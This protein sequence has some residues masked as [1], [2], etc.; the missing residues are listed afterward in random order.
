M[1]IWLPGWPLQRLSLERPELKQRIVLI[2]EDS[3][4]GQHNIVACSKRALQQGIRPGMPK[5]EAEAFL[6][7]MKPAGASVENAGVRNGPQ[8]TTH[9][10]YLS[11]STHKSTLSTAEREGAH[12]A[13]PHTT[14]EPHFE[15]YD[16][17]ID[18]ARLRDLAVWCRRF[19][20]VVGVED[21]TPPECLLLNIEG[22]THLFQNERAMALHV[23]AELH[24]VGISPRIAIAD[25]I[26]MAWAA[27]H[28]ATA[29]DTCASGSATDKNPF[30]TQRRTGK[31]DSGKRNIPVIVPPG[32][33]LATLRALPSVA[34]RLPTDV[35]ETLKEL[36][37]RR[38]HQLLNL[39]K[40][41]LPSRFGDVL[42]KRIDQALGE[43]PE[44][45]TPELPPKST[46]ERWQFEYVI[47]DRR[48]IEMAI[49]KLLN[50][51]LVSL[52][53][54]RHGI[55]RVLIVIQGELGEVVDFTVG[56]IRPT[57][58]MPHLMRLVRTQLEQTL[59][60]DDICEIRIE[61]ISSAPLDP[62]QETLF[63]CRDEAKARRERDQLF[64]RICSRLGEHAVVVAQL[65]PDAQPE[66]GF[67]CES[68]T[69]MSGRALAP[70]GARKSP[71]L[72]KKSRPVVDEATSPRTRLPKSGL[73]ASSTTKL[74]DKAP[75]AGGTAA[76]THGP[77]VPGAS[78]RPLTSWPQRP[79]NLRE[80]PKQLDVLTVSTTGPPAG[81]RWHGRTHPIA[82]SWGPERIHTG[83]WRDDNIVRDYYRVETDEGLR[84]W[85]FRNARNGNWFLHGVFD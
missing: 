34:L 49:E 19:S 46:I 15:L 61:L 16:P 63:A 1:C 2:Y 32:E 10:G 56:L 7:F 45:I 36:D 71:L 50:R 40:S 31:Q 80:E 77:S 5:A 11:S 53:P 76:Q 9:Q 4:R 66:H 30:R 60:P 81:V 35:M 21:A 69:T 62:R 59:T 22:V 73:V 29:T 38:V 55:Q 52:E 25:T 43:V 39:P 57:I 72:R 65:V 79:I 8:N 44:T 6:Q 26:G 68:I 75:A 3:G 23:F 18:R 82:A 42:H 51:T 13:R 14:D 37:L 47:S 78:A 17:T 28:F 70:G 33:A 24:R 74:S 41:T 27:V 67:S 12:A 84:L 48:V 64:E 20:P 54:D 83:W 58:Q 85:V